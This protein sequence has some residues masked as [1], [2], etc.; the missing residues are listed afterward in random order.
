MKMS[1]QRP[2]RRT[3]R[4]ARRFYI[5]SFTGV[6]QNGHESLAGAGRDLIGFCHVAPPKGCGDKSLNLGEAPV[7]AIHHAKLTR[8]TARSAWS[9]S[10]KYSTAVKPN[11]RATILLGKES[12]RMLRFRAAPL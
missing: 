3:N 2:R 12:T 4:R 11:M 8:G 9:S 5:F 1:R 6:V 10:S 7:T